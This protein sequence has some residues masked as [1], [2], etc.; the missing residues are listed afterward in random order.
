L[1]P[2]SQIPRFTGPTVESASPAPRCQPVKDVGYDQVRDQFRPHVRNFLDC[3]KSR[4]TPLADLDGAHQTSI[5]CHLANIAMRTGRV[6]QWDPV[7]NDIVADPAASALLT[8]T[9]R[10]PWD[11]H[12]RGAMGSA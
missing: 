4:Q 9:Y 2:E 8:K 6:I 5:A 7:R 3:I 11:R 1:T 12:L 10:A